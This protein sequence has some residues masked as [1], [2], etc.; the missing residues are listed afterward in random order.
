MAELSRDQLDGVARCLIN[1]KREALRFTQGAQQR[2]CEELK[3]EDLE[4]LLQ[5]TTGISA[6][7]LPVFIWA[8][9]LHELPDLTLEESKGW[10]VAYFPAL[11]A[12]VE[13]TNL[14]LFG[15]PSTPGIDEADDDAA[16]PPSAGAPGA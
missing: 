9:R 3:V 16:D 1:G 15:T 2:L 14:A 11:E 4:G 10:V 12:V 5:A 13:A 8:G 7:T 6:A